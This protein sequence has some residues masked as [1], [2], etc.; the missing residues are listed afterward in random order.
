MLWVLGS[1][2]CLL[3]LGAALGYRLAERK[4]PEPVLAVLPFASLTDQKDD[5]LFCAALTD[6]LVGTLCARTEVD[7]RP[8]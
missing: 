1:A 8:Q 5:S 2:A 3:V 6:E 7:S 4:R